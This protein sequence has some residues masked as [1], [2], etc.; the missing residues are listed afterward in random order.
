ML[1]INIGVPELV[2]VAPVSGC[3]DTVSLPQ[4]QHNHLTSLQNVIASVMQ[5]P[6]PTPAFRSP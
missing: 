6:P 5:T 1:S 2:R 3:P 4:I